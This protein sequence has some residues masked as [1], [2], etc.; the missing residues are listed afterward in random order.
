MSGRENLGLEA[1]HAC[2]TGRGRLGP[3]LACLASGSEPLSLGV[4]R[5]S[6]AGCVPRA[7]LWPAGGLLPLAAVQ[8]ACTARAAS[9]LGHP[10]EGVGGLGSRR[11]W[12][13]GAL[14]CLA[15]VWSG[16]RWPVVL[17]APGTCCLPR[18]HQARAR[19]QPLRCSGQGPEL[20]SGVLGTGPCVCFSVVA[21]LRW[22]RRHEPG[23]AGCVASASRTA[24][25]GGSTV[26]WAAPQVLIPW[27]WGLG[28]RISGCEGSFSFHMRS[29]F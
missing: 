19:V 2:R 1:M 9:G 17:G 25:H 18:S 24:H 14:S 27:G 8:E 7:R 15:L 12:A 16:W 3:C 10:V 23:D 26:G 21:R 6:A 28:I 13:Y 11:P 29:G 4:R 5:W 20:L 22:G